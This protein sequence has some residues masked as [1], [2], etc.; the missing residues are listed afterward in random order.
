MEPRIDP[1]IDLARHLY[2]ANL[3]ELALLLRT[4]GELR[5]SNYL[6]WQ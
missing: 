1:R 5:L 2:P 4:R 6:L 3:P